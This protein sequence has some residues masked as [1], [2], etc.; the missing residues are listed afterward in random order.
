[1][2]LSLNDLVCRR[3]GRRLFGPL[4]L[5]LEAGQALVVTGANGAGKTTLLRMLAGFLPP[6]EGAAVIEADGMKIRLGAA[7]WQEEIAFAGHLDAVKPALGVGENLALWSKLAGAE[8]DTV[9]TALAR[10][11]LER[12]APRPAGE[13]SAGQKRRLGLARLL[14]GNRRVWLLDEP[15]VS[16]DEGSRALVAALIQE[17]C[18]TGGIAVVT[19]HVDLGL[20]EAR[21]LRIEPP[22]ANGGGTAA[23]AEDD[24]FLE[25]SW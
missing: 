18:A 12:M 19:S 14:L 5:T 9:G 20:R 3:G 4:R 21:V 11:G 1:M 15:T 24:P 8:S 22:A 16:L 7:A 6:S 10:F 23:R 13:C 17:H 2:R 25:G